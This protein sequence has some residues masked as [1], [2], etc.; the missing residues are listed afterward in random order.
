M[1]LRLCRPQP[2]QEAALSFPLNDSIPTPTSKVPRVEVVRT[3]L[4]AGNSSGGPSVAAAR[5]AASAHAKYSL[6]NSIRSVPVPNTNQHAESLE[7]W[8]EHE[9]TPFNAVGT[10]SAWQQGPPK[11]HEQIASAPKGSKSPRDMKTATTKSTQMRSGT[12]ANTLRSTMT[13]STSKTTSGLSTVK[14]AG[15][16]RVPARGRPAGPKLEVTGTHINMP[17]TTTTTLPNAKGTGDLGLT[18]SRTTASHQHSASVQ[19]AGRGVVGAV[20]ARGGSPV[21]AAAAQPA[22]YAQHT[23]RPEVQSTAA[24]AASPSSRSNSL[25]RLKELR[26]AANRPSTVASLSKAAARGSGS[27]EASEASDLI[28][29]LD[30]AGDSLGTGDRHFQQSQL[31]PRNNLDGAATGAHLHGESI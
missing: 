5:A 23:V 12:V 2:G 28:S 4:G 22:P 30:A 19:Q 25:A 29:L 27:S 7:Q 6:R 13:N 17:P 15:N 14:A 21:R 26:G 10:F 1:T 9:D 3:S 31:L 8:T 11:M 20:P 24:A 18:R 16:K